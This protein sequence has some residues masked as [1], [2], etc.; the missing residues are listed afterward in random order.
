MRA[1]GRRTSS[2]L[3]V[4]VNRY[5]GETL[6]TRGIDRAKPVYTDWGSK[7]V[8]DHVSAKQTTLE[9]IRALDDAAGARSFIWVHYFDVHEHHQIDVPKELRAAVSPNG[10]EKRHTYRALLFAI[11]REIGRLRAELASRGLADKTIIVLSSDHGESLGEDS[12]LGVTHGKVAYAPLIR[13][14]LAIRVPGVPAGQRT[15]AVS[16]VDI[17]PTV[18]GLLGHPTAMTP[19]EGVDLV[20]VLLDGPAA[21]RPRG[22]AIVVQE[23]LQWAVVEWPH[24]LIVRPADDL[25]EL[26]DLEQ[27]PA[28]RTDLSAKLPDVV[29]RLQARYAA[30]PRVRVDRTTDGRKWRERQ[31][32]PPPSRAPRSGSAATSTP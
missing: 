1:T 16:L 32:Q 29:S 17:A 3:P 23:E 5:V 7:D 9:G 22:R 24:H 14:P 10:G 15:D 11:D 20:P 19:L 18:L 21:L 8:G 2:A 30:A 26:Y 13:I 12:R 31:A 25:V 6:L 4:E 27:D 28:E